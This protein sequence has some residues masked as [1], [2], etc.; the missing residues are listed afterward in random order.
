MSLN[1]TSRGIHAD[2][3]VGKAAPI[4]HNSNIIGDSTAL[5][6]AIA[7][8]EQV[9][10]TD[11]TV[12]I[13]GETG[14]GKEL[15]AKAIHTMSRRRDRRMVTVNCAALPSNLVEA[16][17]FG[18]EK[19][20]YTGALTREQGRF[21]IA[22]G[23]TLFLD[24]IGEL[25]L[26]LQ[27]KL[28]RV[29]Q[30]GEYE[31]LGSPVTQ[32]VDVRIVAATNRDIARSVEKKTFR[33]DLFYRLAVFPIEVPAL[34]ERV[35]DI[36]MLVWGFVLEFSQSMG[37]TI[38]S[39]PVESMELLRSHD[40]PGNVRELRNVIERAMIVSPGP[41]LNVEM[42]S[43][44]SVPHQSSRRLDDVEREHIRAV[45]KSTGWRIRGDGGAAEVLGLK[46]T[47]LEARMKKLGISRRDEYSGS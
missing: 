46:P 28:L 42:P 33:E 13:T 34:R 11:A 6:A 39:I 26:E 30:D 7:K 45:A 40:W 15:L 43:A 3:D 35:D 32:K 4:V 44:K 18:R 29:L 12:L 27:A 14:T 31:R 16:E 38:E 20:A 25:P 9:A 23:S 47:T 24:E 8:A 22:D 37:K 19:G 1:G 5:R 17:L 2:A 41:V 10:P 21:E 36:P